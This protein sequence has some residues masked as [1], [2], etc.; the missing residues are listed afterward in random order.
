MLPYL[1]MKIKIVKSCNQKRKFSEQKKSSHEPSR[2]SP[3]FTEDLA[4]STTET[5]PPR[6]CIAAVKLPEVR[7]LFS[8]NINVN[9]LPCMNIY[10]SGIRLIL[11]IKRFRFFFFFYFGILRSKL[12]V[13]IVFSTSNPFLNF[14]RTIFPNFRPF[15][16]I[17]D[18]RK[19]LCSQKKTDWS[20]I[21]R[22]NFN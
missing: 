16:E 10:P 11:L 17:S 9:C 14:L 8:K 19:K 15:P 6:R 5:L 20:I 13:Y 21:F 7:V 18:P 1:W 12:T 3:F 22:I 2:L 4:T